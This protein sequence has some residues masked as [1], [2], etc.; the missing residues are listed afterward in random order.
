MFEKQ[1][2]IIEFFPEIEAIVSDNRLSRE[3]IEPLLQQTKDFKVRFPLVGAFSSGKSSLLNAFIGEPIF[4]TSIDPQTAI[5]AE[6]SYNASESFIAHYSDS[7]IKPI[8]KE[9][10]RHNEL[11]E[12]QPDGLIEVKLPV[13][14]LKLLPHLLLVDM[15]GWDSG[16]EGHARAIDQYAARSLAYGVVVSAE[17][18]NLRESLRNALLE[19]K[20]LDMPIVVI[21]SKC[22]KKTSEEIAAVSSHIRQEIEATIGHSP[23]AVACIS[24]R[25]KNISEF[26]EAL[27][28]LEKEAE[29]LFNKKVVAE[30]LRQLTTITHHFNILL[31][32]EDLDSEQIILKQQE[33][34]REIT[35]FEQQFADESRLL[36]QK[37]SSITQKILARIRSKL[38]DQL[39]TLTSQLMH[40]GDIN[41]TLGQGEIVNV[42]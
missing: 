12:L 36:D 37:M 30:V 28:L 35:V 39:S 13:S 9:S 17:E 21:I 31:N 5:P 38:T 24:S 19:L 2:Q 15:P 29:G 4:A 41:G 6:L 11:S 33:L 42:L 16:I 32:K 26:V 7:V 10:I 22:D 14:N 34:K 1:K 23:L 20:V 3:W 40:G 8:S 25:K 27:E 18:G